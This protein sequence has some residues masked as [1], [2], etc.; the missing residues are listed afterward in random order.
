MSDVMKS[1]AIGYAGWKNSKE[2]TNKK[3]KKTG[4]PSKGRKEVNKKVRFKGLEK[5]L[6]KQTKNSEAGKDKA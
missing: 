6:A 4:K 3:Q 1:I 2:C 5:W